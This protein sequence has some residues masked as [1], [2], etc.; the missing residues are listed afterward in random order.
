MEKLLIYKYIYNY[1][2][3]LEIILDMAQNCSILV[4]VSKNIKNLKENLYKH[5][6]S[7]YEIDYLLRASRIFDRKRTF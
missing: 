7:I 5:F 6:R 2:L 3:N 4:A 1:S